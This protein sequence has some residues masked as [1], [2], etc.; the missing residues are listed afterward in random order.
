MVREPEAVTSVSRFRS[1]FLWK[2]LMLEEAET[3]CC[4]RFVVT[5]RVVPLIYFIWLPKKVIQHPVINLPLFKL[6]WMDSVLSIRNPVEKEKKLWELE[7]WSD[8]WVPHTPQSPWIYAKPMHSWDTFSDWCKSDQVVSIFNHMILMWPI[9]RA[10][11]FWCPLIPRNY[12]E[13]LMKF[14]I[15]NVPGIFLWCGLIEFVS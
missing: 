1:F 8:Q 15:K 13:V 7:I 6:A 5:L 3:V 12:S 10:V 11:K 4:S 14:S 2:P 9:P